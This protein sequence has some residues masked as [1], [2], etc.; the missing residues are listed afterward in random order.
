M[1]TIHK[2]K[3]YPQDGKFLEIL[4]FGAPLEITK[5]EDTFHPHRHFWVVYPSHHSAAHSFH[6]FFWRNNK[7]SELPSHARMF[8]TPK[9]AIEFA[10][11]MYCKYLAEEKK[12]LDEVEAED[13]KMNSHYEEVIKIYPQ[14]KTEYEETG[15][16]SDDSITKQGS[17]VFKNEQ[18]V[19]ETLKGL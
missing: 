18:E 5:G 8:K 10:R 2:L 4:G 17:K 1:F 15:R 19:E 6:E 7:D 12:K 13:L 16:I 14:L 3:N 9:K 11:E